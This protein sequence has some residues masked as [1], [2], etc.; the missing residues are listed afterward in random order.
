M[1]LGWEPGMLLGRKPGLLLGW[2]P[3]MLLSW[4]P[5][6]LLGWEP[7]ML[8]S[9]EP[10]MLQQVF[11]GWI[12]FASSIHQHQTNQGKIKCRVLQKSNYSIN[13]APIYHL[14][15]VPSHRTMECFYRSDALPV[16]QPTMSM[17]C[18]QHYCLLI[19]EY[20]TFKQR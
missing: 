7:G 16:T 1:L 12:P 6:M 2:E 18:I 10:G 5:R 11:A 8:L 9:W 3:G 15:C 4:E 17:H 20:K 13:T 19:Y 14:L